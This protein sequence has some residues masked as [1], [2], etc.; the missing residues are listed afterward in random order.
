M[1]KFKFTLLYLDDVLLINAVIDCFCLE[2]CWNMEMS[3]KFAYFSSHRRLQIYLSSA[4]T[5]ERVY[6]LKRIFSWTNLNYSMTFQ[7]QVLLGIFQEYVLKTQAFG[8][9]IP[10]LTALNGR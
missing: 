10:R 3:E 5:F 1:R 8:V 7:E 6:I 4:F 9:Q 2:A